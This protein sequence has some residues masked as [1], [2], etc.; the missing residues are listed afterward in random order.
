MENVECLQLLLPRHTISA[1]VSAKD[2]LKQSLGSRQ[3]ESGSGEMSSSAT[4]T[5]E[6]MESGA[7]SH[8]HGVFG[9]VVVSIVVGCVLFVVYHG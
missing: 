1:L 9:D 5:E 7:F 2:I 3:T 8:K 6:S 4:S